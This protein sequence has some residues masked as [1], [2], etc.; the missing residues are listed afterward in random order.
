[1]NFP[2]RFESERL[3]ALPIQTQDWTALFEAVSSDRF[4]SKL[5]LARI[6][7]QEQAQCWSEERVKEW[8]LGTAFVWSLRLNNSTDVIGQI[9]LIPQTS[10]YALAYWVHPKYWKQGFATEACSALLQ[11]LR[12]NTNNCRIWAGTQVWNMASSAVLETLGFKFQRTVTHELVNG[13]NE[14]ILE[15]VLAL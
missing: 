6:K 8:K 4:P 1:M 9:S 15:Y 5:P 10:D 7:T 11:H 2:I 12:I 13:N 14:Q 3:Q